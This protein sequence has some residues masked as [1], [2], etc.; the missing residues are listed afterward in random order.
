MEEDEC[1]VLL[2]IVF[3]RHVSCRKKKFQPAVPSKEKGWRLCTNLAVVATNHLHRAGS[4]LI[5]TIQIF[6]RTLF[7]WRYNYVCSAD[8][9]WHCNG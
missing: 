9:E 8:N 3:L 5:E 1:I 6:S 7:W 4:F 2:V